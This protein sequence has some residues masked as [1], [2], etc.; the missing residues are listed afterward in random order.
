MRIKLYALFLGPVGFGIIS[1]L[2]NFFL[3][4]T[5]VLNLG[6]PVST[7]SEIS[8]LHS[9]GTEES[10]NKIAYYFRYI[11]IRIV[12]LSVLL[13]AGVIIF[14]GYISEFLVD[15]GAYYYFLV[16]IFLAAPFTILYSIMEAFLRSFKR[17]NTIVN[18]SVITNIST[19]AILVPLVY[20]LNITGV[21]IYLLIFGILPMLLFFFYGRDIIKKYSVKSDYLPSK[22]DRMLIFKVGLISLLSSLIHQGIIILIRKILITEY[23]YEQNGLYQ[24]V[25]SVSITY[26][27]LIYIFLTN[28]S[29][30]KLSECRDNETINTELSHNLR[31]LLLII[32][33]MMLVFLGY[34]DIL[35]SLLFSK[36]FADTTDLFIPQFAGDLFRVGAALFGLWLIPRR[37]IKQ[38]IIIDVIFNTVLIST[39]YLFVAVL[40]KP[41][42]YVSYAYAI[43]FGLHFLMYFVYSSVSIK[44]RA[45][46]IIL[47]TFFLTFASIA[48]VSYLSL[49]DSKISYY[50][51]PAIIIVWF[52]LAVKRD[53]INKTKNLI[54]DYI[55]KNK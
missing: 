45:D 5:S 27:S 28:Y 21:S 23:G 15:D 48:A 51:T 50:F 10:E 24:S 11:A 3:L 47:L 26:F 6:V 34:R 49:I 52:F 30:P 1:Q 7:T 8:K 2:N 14:S 37:K 17:I 53:E 55:N 29:L 19:V 42:V 54:L 35:V 32:T 41:L 18:I 46:K 40:N 36:N 43:S 4:F 20:Y 38:I 22:Q 12:M 16:I 31:F 33:P 13:S 39:V 9:E 44:F 25:L